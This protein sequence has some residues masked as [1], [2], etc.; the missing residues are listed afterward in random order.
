MRRFFI[1]LTLA[2]FASVAIAAPGDLADAAKLGNWAQVRS[3]LAAKGDVRFVQADGM[4][5][6]HWA[7]QADQKDIVTALLAAGA[8]ANAAN[9]YGITPLWLAATNG[10][11]AVT[12]L[13]LKAGA[14]PTTALPHGETALMTAARTGEPETVRLLLDA[15]ADPNV[16][17]T[18]QGE[19]ALM[20]AAAENH[21]EAIRALITGGTKRDSN[22]RGAK[23]KGA[24]P[25][26]HA[27]GLDLAPMKWMQVGMVDTMLPRGGFTALM[28]AARQDA[29]DAVRALADS[30]ADLNAQDPDGATAM[31]LAII[32][33]HYD[34]A[35]MLVEKGANANVADNSGMTSIYAL[36][37]MNTFRSDIGRPTRPLLDKMNALDVLRLALRHGG[38]PDARLHKPILGRHH[39]FGDNTL[40]EGA[41]ALMRAAKG[42]DMDAL[43]VLLDD[44]ANTSL[45]M[46]NGSNPLLIMAGTRVGSGPGA[47]DK[48][49]SAIRLL[50]KHGADLN[51]KQKGDT[52]LL[53][54]A[55]QGSNAVVKLL[56]ELGADLDVK[57]SSGKTALEAVSQPGR[58]AHEDTAALLK[59]ISVEPAQK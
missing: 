2:A 42:N 58:S 5:A 36:V 49:V 41:T 11:A 7:V 6:L 55:K 20:W 34:L 59:Q 46:A 40:S 29:K 51:S 21:A 31:H 56:A 48:L 17:E 26:L 19:T 25:N 53:L 44:G 14:D 33:Q 35:G 16:R 50:V 27:K 22:Q 52:A 15:G 4:T 3:L 13:L 24:D 57:D 37:D 23:L 10:S 1:A 28:Y 32:N 54:A 45:G 9:R 18:S 43:L 38:D 8:P 30:G 12:G 47:A 39:G